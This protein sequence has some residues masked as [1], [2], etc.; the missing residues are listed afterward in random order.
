MKL[1]KHIKMDEVRDLI[2]KMLGGIT[3]NIADTVVLK[4]TIDYTDDVSYAFLSDLQDMLR[5]CH[6]M[7][8]D[9]LGEFDKEYMAS[10][11]SLSDEE[12]KEI[13]EVEVDDDMDKL[14]SDNYTIPF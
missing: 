2:V 11:M 14:M 6:S 13:D 7:A 1:S 9:F 5:Y 12:K 4:D 3:S 8:N 10:R